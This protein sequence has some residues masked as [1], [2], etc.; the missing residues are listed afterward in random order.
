M[1]LWKNSNRGFTLAELLVA[2]AILGIMAAIATPSLQKMACEVRLKSSARQISALLRH[3]KE[4]AAL[5][6]RT[7]VVILTLPNHYELIMESHLPELLE[8][9]PSNPSSLDGQLEEGIS[10]SEFQG[11]GKEAFSQ[12]IRI[13]FKEHGMVT[14][15]NV[16]LIAQ[17]ISTKYCVR[18]NDSGKIFLE[19]KD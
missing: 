3:A 10:F 2:I 8:S 6:G 7:Y 16:Y 5:G 9:S 11:E 18:V 14:P 13:T 1:I 15:A 12:R 19:R 17:Y 4:E